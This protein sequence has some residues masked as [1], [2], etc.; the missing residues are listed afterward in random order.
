MEVSA[1]SYILQVSGTSSKSLGTDSISSDSR[2]ARVEEGKG[3]SSQDKVNLSPE[4]RDVSQRNIFSQKDEKTSPATAPEEAE[5]TAEEQQQ[6]RDLKARDTEVKTHEQAHLSAAGQYAAGGAAFTFQQGPDGQRYAIGGEVPI[7]VSK[8]N[9]PEETI[10]KMN[11][12]RSA[13]LAP[14]EP[15]AADRQ[16]AAQASMTAAQARQELVAERQSEK[17]DSDK[18]ESLP[19]SDT[20]MKTDASGQST[21]SDTE[22]GTTV[23]AM[24]NAY[25]AIQ[26]LGTPRA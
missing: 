4:S 22:D 18:T 13:A 8:A 16:I 19:E 15:S 1:S 26:A 17:T 10:L 9:T 6:L 21:S 23:S 24:I 7:D 20:D 2:D 3:F 12:I 14:A 11:I 25:T 5:L